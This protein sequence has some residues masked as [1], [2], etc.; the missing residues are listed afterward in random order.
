[1]KKLTALVAASALLATA[2]AQAANNGIEGA[3]ST[4]DF[5]VDLQIGNIVLVSNLDDLAL[6]QH[7]T[8]TDRNGTEAFCIGQNY[9]GNV[10]ITVSGASAA[11]GFN[12]VGN[13][14]ASPPLPY[15]VSWHNG[16]G[17]AGAAVADGG[18]IDAAL[19]N[20]QDLTC[21]SDNIELSVNVAA[22]VLDVAPVDYYSDLITVQVAA[23]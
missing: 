12:L 1:M 19:S 10:D 4:G 5:Q 23:Q 16:V 21:A 9:G 3:T 11:A 14:P 2:G 22:A 6:G 18:L 20:P 7:V 15:A 13:L 17:A 8:G